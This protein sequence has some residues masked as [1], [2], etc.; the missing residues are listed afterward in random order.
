MMTKRVSAV[1]LLFLFLSFS[2]VDA[3][4]LQQFSLSGGSS[5]T[6]SVDVVDAWTNTTGRP[7][8]IHSVH[9]WIGTAGSLDWPKGSF[10]VVDV[11]V[12]LFREHGFVIATL[13]LDHYMPFSGVHQIEKAFPPPHT[14][15]VAPGQRV[16]IQHFCKVLEVG[17]A[18]GVRPL[19]TLSV[20]DDSRGDNLDRDGKRV[21]EDRDAQMHCPITRPGVRPHGLPH[22]CVSTPSQREEKQE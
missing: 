14:V 15:T 19:A 2:V 1:L 20:H 17:I 5:C 4:E 22:R 12:T 9:L 3:A 6:G 13:G 18:K 10:P 21:R 7:V 16:I 11:G 8:Q